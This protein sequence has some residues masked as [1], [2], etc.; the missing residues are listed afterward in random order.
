M[1]VSMNEF[2]VQHIASVKNKLGVIA[3]SMIIVYTPLALYFQVT[4][5]NIEKERLKNEVERCT[6][7]TE[8][9]EASEACAH[10]IYCKDL[11]NIKDGSLVNKLN[12]LTIEI[13]KL[14]VEMTTLVQSQPVR[15]SHR[16]LTKNACVSSENTCRMLLLQKNLQTPQHFYL[17][18]S[19]DA[20]ADSEK[21]VQVGYKNEIKRK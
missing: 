13:Q 21:S 10:C 3:F 7:K 18:N 12:E 1:S 9:V 2:N 19:S 15:E 16:V 14:A 11:I 8:C 5:M 6:I 17:N 4:R 20:K